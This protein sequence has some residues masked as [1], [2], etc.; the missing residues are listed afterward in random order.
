MRFHLGSFLIG[1]FWLSISAQQNEKTVFVLLGAD[2]RLLGC[3]L[4]PF[5]RRKAIDFVAPKGCCKKAV[6]QSC[7]G[8]TYPDIS[9]VGARTVWIADEKSVDV[10]HG[11]LQKS[12]PEAR[13]RGVMIYRE[14][15]AELLDIYVSREAKKSPSRDFAAFLAFTDL[16]ERA[17]SPLLK[18]FEAIFEPKQLT[19]V[20]K[21]GLEKAQ[22]ELDSWFVTEV[23][24]VDG[25]AVL[26]QDKT[27]KL[28]PNLV[29]FW[30]FLQELVAV[31]QI[32]VPDVS[33]PSGDEKRL[34]C[35]RQEAPAALERLK[36]IH[37]A[38]HCFRM[39]PLVAAQTEIDL[40]AI[41]ASSVVDARHLDFLEKAVPKYSST[42][43][44]C[45]VFP[46]RLVGQVDE[47]FWASLLGIV[48]RVQ[49]GS[50]LPE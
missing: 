23:L 6:D 39:E 50:C 37:S 34:E 4:Q 47:K 32:D 30:A 20:C 5:F 9:A 3:H 15:F 28:D 17:L 14:R 22:L 33:F 21:E 19:V 2:A 8:L 42:K 13:L 26:P 12:S 1:A 27:P 29:S 10:W 11:L 41:K 46:A 31:R 45:S 16:Q 35:L 38:W 43:L 49:S 44:G 18:G 48:E 40:Q 24:G 7:A 25:G 36:E